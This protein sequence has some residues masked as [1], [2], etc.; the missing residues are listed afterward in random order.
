MNQNGE[1]NSDIEGMIENKLESNLDSKFK[2]FQDLM[3]S[4]MADQFANPV[5]Q[6]IYKNRG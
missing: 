3:M 2:E 6:L 4:N 1:Q 5:A